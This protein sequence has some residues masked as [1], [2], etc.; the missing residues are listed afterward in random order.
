M[1]LPR[2]I[3]RRVASP[4]RVLI[5]ERMTDIEKRFAGNGHDGGLI[6]R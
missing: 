2:S 1:N 6:E 3:A 5:F 4:V